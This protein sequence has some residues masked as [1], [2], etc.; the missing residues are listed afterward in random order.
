MV[1]LRLEWSETLDKIARWAGRQ[2]ARDRQRMIREMDDAEAAEDAPGETN[3]SGVAGDPR[4]SAKA[5]L[6]ARLAQNRRIG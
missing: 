3:G 4:H 1:Q 2:A 5:A 6:R